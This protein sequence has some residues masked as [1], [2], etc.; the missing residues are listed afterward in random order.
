MGFRIDT[1]RQIAIHDE[2]RWE[3]SFKGVE[4]RGE[5]ATYYTGVGGKGLCTCEFKPGGFALLP[6]PN[7]ERFCAPLGMAQED[8]SS[9]VA[10]WMK[11]QGW[12]P[13]L[14]QH[15]QTIQRE[16]ARTL[17]SNDGSGNI[18]LA[19]TPELTQLLGW[20]EGQVMD[21]QVVNG[22]LTITPVRS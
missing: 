4:G 7:S 1:V 17:S 15:H 3:I 13:E 20:D 10:M 6:V 9:L 16:M 5:Y 8:V 12:G 18:L 22:S 21:V 19:F 11:L 2:L 14:D